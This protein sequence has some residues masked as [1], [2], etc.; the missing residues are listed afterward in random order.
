[1]KLYI[2]GQS[3]GDSWEFQG[4]FSTE[5]KALKACRN[6]TYFIGPIKLDKSLPAETCDWKDAYY[7]G[8]K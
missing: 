2:V 6:R 5:K 8:E 3:K 7:P 1:M 4:V